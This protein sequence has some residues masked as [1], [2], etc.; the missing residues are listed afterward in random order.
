MRCYDCDTQHNPTTEAS[1]TCSV[2]GAGLCPEHLIEGH[3]EER[4]SLSLGNPAV[5]RLHGRRIFCHTCAPD[6]LEDSGTRTAAEAALA[7]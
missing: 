6:H 5:R 4:L 3:A 2:C 1:A 7:G